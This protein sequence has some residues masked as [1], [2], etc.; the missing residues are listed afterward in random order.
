MKLT[1]K[2][3]RR[4]NPK[5]ENPEMKDKTHERKIVTKEEK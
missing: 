5:E 2:K 1:E 4:H 3:I